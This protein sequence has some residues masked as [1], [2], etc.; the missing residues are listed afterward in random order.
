LP[1]SRL[2]LAASA[3]EPAIPPPSYLLPKETNVHFV[4]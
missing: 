2:F 1:I 3:A 4:S